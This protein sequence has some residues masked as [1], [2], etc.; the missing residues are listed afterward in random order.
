MI[1]LFKKSQSS[2]IKITTVLKQLFKKILQ[3]WMQFWNL[4]KETLKKKER[5]KSTLHS[6]NQTLTT[7]FLT[8]QPSTN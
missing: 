2:K 5:K 3:P 8:I 6:T 1:N 7:F 4:E